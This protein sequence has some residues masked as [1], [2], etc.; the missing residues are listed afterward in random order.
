MILLESLQTSLT[1]Q[2]SSSTPFLVSIHG[3]VQRKQS[4]LR[5]RRP[6]VSR[7]FSTATATQSVLERCSA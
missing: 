6:Y 3:L 2:S 5:H 4:A 1:V 7:Y